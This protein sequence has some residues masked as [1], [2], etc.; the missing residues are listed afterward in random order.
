[1]KRRTFIRNSALVSA[2]VSMGHI[3][4]YSR[5][6][7]GRDRNIFT[8]PPAVEP[9]TGVLPEFSPPEDPSITAG[10]WRLRYD[11]IRWHEI[12]D[13]GLPLNIDDGGL[14]VRRRGSSTSGQY[15][16][17]RRMGLPV[18]GFPGS[19]I[20]IMEA[21]L[22]TAGD[23]ESLRDW[24]LTTFHHEPGRGG[25]EQPDSRNTI[26][27]SYD[28]RQVRLLR[29]SELL[30]EWS[31]EGPLI[32]SWSIPELLLRSS[33]DRTRPFHFTMLEDG[34]LLRR[35]QQLVYEGSIEFETASGKVNFDSWRQ[36]GTGIL[37]IHWITD[38][39]GCPQIRTHSAMNW[40]LSS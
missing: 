10:D 37:P 1:M 11:L 20:C 32:A 24:T 12:Q 28:G 33:I 19:Q 27:G 23:A 40:L 21:E 6:L 36:T 5:S 18:W 15:S 8:I 17:N 25:P 26:E 38:Q 2:L 9:I 16:I 14:V 13:N 22:R 30:S 7:K 39:R 31:L 4:C 29:Q 34:H 3:P 35:N